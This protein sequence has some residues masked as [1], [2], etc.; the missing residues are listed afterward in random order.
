MLQEMVRPYFYQDF[1]HLLEIF[2]SNINNYF[3]TAHFP[4]RQANTKYGRGTGEILLDNLICS[5]NETSLL[6]CSHNSLKLTNCAD[7][8]SEDAGVI[9][10]GILS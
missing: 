4:I 9:C 2:I 8:H 5:G 6:N 3:H 1:T 10:G 7:D